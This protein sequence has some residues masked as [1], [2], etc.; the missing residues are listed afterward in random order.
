LANVATAVL[1]TGAARY[2]STLKTKGTAPMMGNRIGNRLGRVTGGHGPVGRRDTGDRPLDRE[3]VGVGTPL[4]RVQDAVREE[5]VKGLSA[6]QARDRGMLDPAADLD[7]ARR[8][9]AR[10]QAGVRRP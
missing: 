6:A 8:I 5:R 9:T 4:E 1:E 3:A 7:A 2:T 10:A